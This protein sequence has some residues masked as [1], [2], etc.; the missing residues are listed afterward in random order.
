MQLHGGKFPRSRKLEQIF[1]IAPPI[2][3]HYP[4]IVHKLFMEKH[5]ITF[6]GDKSQRN[7]KNDLFSP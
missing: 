1:R 4:E 5:Q 2:L 3:N 7:N 6:Y